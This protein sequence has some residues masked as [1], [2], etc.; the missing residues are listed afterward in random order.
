MD[1]IT[2][3][4]FSLDRVLI[5]IIIPG[6]F[7]IFPYLVILSDHPNI[8]YGHPNIFLKFFKSEYLAASIPL[9]IFLSIIVGLMLENIGSRI[10]AYIY[11]EM[12]IK[13]E[14]FKDFTNDWWKYL[15]IDFIY[16]PIGQEY[17]RSILM[18]MKFELS[19]GIAC[20]LVLPGW[21]Q[22]VHRN[23]HI[24]SNCREYSITIIILFGLFIW[25]MMEGY[26]SSQILARIRKELVSKFY[27]AE[28]NQIAK[29]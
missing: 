26:S 11:D 10:E 18:R 24:Y 27:S 9:T 6:A 15:K 17:L 3:L 8:L 29:N 13:N 21:I 28:K 4:N 19:F 1:K 12:H 14:K 20:L 5:N 7:L 16:E 2:S 22:I 23:I 25:L